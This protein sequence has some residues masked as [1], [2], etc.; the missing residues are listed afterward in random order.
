MSSLHASCTIT[1]VVSLLT[2]CQSLTYGTQPNVERIVPNVVIAGSSPSA[3]IEG[4]DFFASAHISL[5]DD[6]PP[7]IE[8]RYTVRLGGD[9][10]D[11]TALGSV[12]ADSLEIVVPSD[13]EVGV[14][15]VEV[16]SLFGDRA[17]LE[18][19]LRVIDETSIDLVIE[20]APGGTGTA[21]EQRE[22]A[23]TASTAA[24]AVGRYS[25]NDQFLLDLEVSWSATGA[26]S[27]AQTSGTTTTVTPTNLGPATLIAE[28]PIHGTASASLQIT[29]CCTNGGTPPVADFVVDQSGGVPT[30]VFFFDGST[31]RAPEDLLGLLTFDWDWDSDGEFDETGVTVSKSFATVGLHEVTLRVTDPDG[32]TDYFHASV[33]VADPTDMIVVD[34]DNDNDDPA[35][36]VTSLREAIKAA[37]NMARPNLITF[38]GPMTIDVGT[39]AQEP[40]APLEPVSGDAPTY[41]MG[42]PEVIINGAAIDPGEGCLVVRG[43]HSA[44]MWLEFTNCN[45]TGIILDA[46]YTTVAH[47]SLHDSGQPISMRGAFNVVGPDNEVHDNTD[48]GIVAQGTYGLVTGNR[49]WANESGISTQGDS[50]DSNTFIGNTSYRNLEHGIR[51]KNNA[52]ATAILHNTCHDN[53]E[54]G[55]YLQN[56]SEN[57]QLHSNVVTAN[58]GAGI[59]V[60]G[61]VGL[62][63]Y[64]VYFGNQMAACTGCTP[65]PN[66]QEQ[67]PSFIDPSTDDLRVRSGSICI[68]A[69]AASGEDVNGGGPGLYYGARPDVGAWEAP[70][71]F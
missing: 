21:I 19:G 18:N 45:E 29:G 15:D 4:S 56:G 53:A 2:A 63:D 30:T 50:A 39:W 33:Y 59:S 22:L 44:I 40:G 70:P 67:D 65:G 7:A 43:D 37:N 31:T 54:N 49:L 57:T 16:I 69:G 25:E 11:A 6:A 62:H 26:V 68:D 36:G 12:T 8:R 27:V 42:R 1:V 48:I 55:I 47:C 3:V 60:A 32:L 66:A 64:N 28:H 24:Y 52:T 9:I 71:G 51:V 46:D 5:D 35:D 20:D 10:L 41:I 17:L 23:P 14:H 38:A 13:L 58:N 61:S 34:T